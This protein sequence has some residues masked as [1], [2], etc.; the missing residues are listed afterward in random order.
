MVTITINNE[1]VEADT[2]KEAQKKAAILGRKQAKEEKAQNERYQKAYTHGYA[3]IGKLCMAAWTDERSGQLPRGYKAHPASDQWACKFVL[4]SG[5][6]GIY[7]AATEE[8]NCDYETFG[9]NVTHEIQNGG[10]F[11]MAIRMVA[12]DRPEQICWYALGIYKDQM[13]LVSLP[14]ILIPVL[15][16]MAA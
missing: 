15:E 1:T 10:G 3:A 7:T 6:T 11:G 9:Y 5:R 12:M 8:G 2:L 16:A 14:T 13:A 4:K